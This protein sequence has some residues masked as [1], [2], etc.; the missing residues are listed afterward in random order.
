MREDS[1]Y[2]VGIKLLSDIQ[3]EN[4]FPNYKKLLE[5]IEKYRSATMFLSKDYTEKEQYYLMYDNVFSIMGKRGTGKTSA[6]F[7]LRK[8]IEEGQQ[9]DVVLPII[10]P[11]VI[12]EECSILVWILAIVKEKVQILEQRINSICK[13]E[14]KGEFW[15]IA[16]MTKK[17][18]V[19]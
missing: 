1:F 17:R 3:L 4:I 6:A 10:I 7:T 16:I 2:K 11:E 8:K 19:H 18:I 15:K 9:C 12:P 13:K 5:E 14:E